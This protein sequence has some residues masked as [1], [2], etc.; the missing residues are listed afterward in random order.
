MIRVLVIGLIVALSGSSL[1]SGPIL[2]DKRERDRLKKETVYAIDLIQRYHYKQKSFS[3]IDAEELLLQYIENLDST[4]MFFLQ[5]DV[6]FIIDRF[7]GT[8]KPSYLYVGDLYPAFEIFNLYIERVET[9]LAWGKERLTQPFNLESDDTYLTD[10]DEAPWPATIEEADRLWEKRLTNELIMELLEDEPM[11]R[12]LDRIVK[13][14]ERMEKYINEIEVHN[15]QETF[16]T[17]LAQLYDPHSNFFSWDSAQEFDIQISNAL[18]GIG[19]QLRD[20]DG[21]CVIERLL[22]GGPAEMAGKLHPGDKIVAVSQGETEP[23]DVVG[24]KLRKIVQMIRGEEGTEVR[25]TVIPAHSAK[26]K[27]ITLVREKVELTANLANADLYEIPAENGD[28]KRIGVIELPSFYGEG[29]FG[30]G[31]ISTSRDVEEL[32]NKLKK[33]DV[34]GI[35]LDLRNNGGG[36]LDEAIKLTGLFISQG[37]VVMKRSFDGEVEEDWDRDQ[38]VAWD[39]PLVV[40][41][42]RASASA[43]EIVAGALQSLDRA[44]VVGDESTHGK[45]T[46]QAPIDLR[47]T[48]RALPFS[49]TLEVGTVKITVQQFYLPNGDSTQNRGVISDISLPSANMFLFDGEA[50]LDNALSWDH[51]SP[52]IYQLPERS[53]PDFTLVQNNLLESL[54]TKSRQRQERSEEFEFLKE[55]IAWYKERHDM[56]Y[57]SLNLEE[58]RQEKEEL[59]ELRD[60]FE[61]IRN[62]LSE[63]LAYEVESVKL[64]LTKLKEEAH[65]EKLAST[66]LPGGRERANQFYQKVFYYQKAPGEKIHEIWVEYFDYDKALEESEALAATLQEAS[67]I[68]LG[69][70]E[71]EEIL[72]RFKNKDRGTDFNVLDPF[73][74][75]L[76]EDIDQTALLEAMPAFFTKLVEIDPDIL[77]ERS[78][79]DIP[80]RESLRIVRDWIEIDSP[81]NPTQIANVVSIDDETE[82]TAATP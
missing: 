32:I 55:N 29:A 25:L 67:G 21:Y 44:I 79:L 4:R 10:R 64:E 50:D 36:R 23:V 74:A 43:S 45:G 15:V 16:L 82:D 59:E 39:G 18:V 56:K 12:A 66:P 31:T 81:L 65:Q 3:D 17:S 73:T 19:A 24:M 30:E 71:T 69:K 62:N 60:R 52:I 1:Y 76:G 68:E 37:P 20:V 51:I 14:R 11:D 13:R 8:L 33:Q 22:P 48:M 6:D 41:V 42:S 72:T 40:L 80:L 38:K 35:V 26:R 61:E 27:V 70:E 9:R 54:N 53:N 46:V 28:L 34:E 75:V 77:L 7:A 58:R 5:E 47:S 2:L 57:V 63:E 49:E 78:K